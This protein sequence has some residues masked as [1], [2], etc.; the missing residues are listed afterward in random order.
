MRFLVDESL[1]WR[2]AR[3]L[4]QSGHDACHAADI[5]LK[6]G[7]DRDVFAFARAEGRVIITQDIDFEHLLVNSGSALPSVILFRTRDGK[8]RT[9]AAI[10]T[11]NLGAWEAELSAGAIITIQ[12][13]VILLHR[14]A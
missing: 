6:S 14:L 2:L 9:H 13:H 7:T 3:A 11:A 12:D 5:G 1:S 10:L 4:R 8:W